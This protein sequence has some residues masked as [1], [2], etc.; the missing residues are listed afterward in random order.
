MKSDTLANRKGDALGVGGM[1]GVG[2]AIGTGVAGIIVIATHNTHNVGLWLPIGCAL[3]TA[4]GTA[5][6]LVLPKTPQWRESSLKAG[7]HTPAPF[8]KRPD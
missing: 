3:G 4:L 8:D 6:Y 2:M 5:L 1:I 7:V